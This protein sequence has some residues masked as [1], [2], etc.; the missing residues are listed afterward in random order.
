MSFIEKRKKKFGD[1]KDGHLIKDLPMVNKILVTL[2]P[3]RC[4]NEVSSTFDL[5]ITN[6]TK[7]INKRKKDDPSCEIKFFHCFIAALVRVINDK[8]KLLRFVQNRKTYEKDEIR[9]SFVAKRAFNE[10]AE[11]AVINYFAKKDDNVDSITRFIINEVKGARDVEQVKLKEE[12]GKSMES[13]N[14]LPNFIFR[15]LGWFLRKTDKHGWTPKSAMEQDPSFATVLLSNLGS[16][17]FKSVYHHL[18]NYGTCSFMITIGQI[19]D[20]VI[21]N[22]KGKK[23]NRTY[24]D[25]TAIFDERIADGFYFINAMKLMQEYLNHPEVLEKAFDEEVKF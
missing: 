5:D 6:L 18:N 10:K 17:G 16:I 20:K 1:R 8:R 9:V 12:D 13:L 19:V 2:Y 3:N 7:Y 11:E 25:V 22:K 21:V 14:K 23:E 4:D 15:L 24:V